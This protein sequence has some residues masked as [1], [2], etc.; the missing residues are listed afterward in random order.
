MTVFH[1]ESTYADYLQQKLQYKNEETCSEH[2]FLLQPWPITRKPKMIIIWRIP[3]FFYHL[4]QLHYQPMDPF[5]HSK[6]SFEVVLEQLTQQNHQKNENPECCW[7]I[8][9]LVFGCSNRLLLLLDPFVPSFFLMMPKSIAIH[10][11]Y[12]CCCCYCCSWCCSCCWCCTW[13]NLHIAKVRNTKY[14]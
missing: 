13:T 9:Q 6:G 14:L 5:H 4:R 3:H 8:H 10:S 12:C 2:E 7:S 1:Q 11:C